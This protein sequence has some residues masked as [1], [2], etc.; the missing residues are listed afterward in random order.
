MVDFRSL[1]EKNG[2]MSQRVTQKNKDRL[3]EKAEEKKS[4]KELG[5]HCPHQELS[6][7]SE[8]GV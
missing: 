1:V 4:W 3:G 6:P 7:G 5:D 2:L 8:A